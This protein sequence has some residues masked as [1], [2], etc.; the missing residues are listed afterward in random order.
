MIR[1]K[2]G[3][4]FMNLITKILYLFDIFNDFQFYAKMRQV[5][6]EYNILNDMLLASHIGNR[7]KFAEAIFCYLIFLKTTL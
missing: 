4:H 2:F 6:M 7:K 1:K 3:V 5:T